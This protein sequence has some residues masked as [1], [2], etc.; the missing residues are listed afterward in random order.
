MTAPKNTP[1]KVRVGVMMEGVQLSDVIGIDIL[2]NLSTDF[3][4]AAIAVSPAHADFAGLGVPFEFFYMA[5]TLE[6]A[7]VLPSLR[8]VPNVTYDSCPRDLDIVIMGGPYMHHRPPQADKFMKEAWGKV[9]VWMSTC[10][11]SLWLASSG[12]LEGKGL[13]ATTNRMMLDV[14]RGVYPGVE[15]VE[16]RWVVQEKEYDGEGKGELWTSGGAGCGECPLCVW[17]S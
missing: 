6:P 4:A 1:S 7:T 16:Q 5:T 15:W 11:G 3:V 9:R 2:G 17:R 14:A 10:M 8:F 13:K 12:V